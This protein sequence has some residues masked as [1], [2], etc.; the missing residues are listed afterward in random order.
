M[1]MHF[2]ELCGG[3]IYPDDIA[4]IKIEVKGQLHR[5]YFHNR[6]FGDCLARKLEELRQQFASRDAAT[7][8]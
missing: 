5:F 7:H 3:A 4:P 1:E 6:Y 2:C 8:N